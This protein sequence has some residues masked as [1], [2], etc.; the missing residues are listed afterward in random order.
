MKIAIITSVPMAP[1]WDQGDKNLAYALTQALNQHRFRI[2]TQRGGPVPSGA[3]LDTVPIY[4]SRRPSLLQKAFVYLQMLASYPA[5]GIP[6]PDS[7]SHGNLDIYHLIYQPT[8]LSASIGKWLPAF[9]RTPILHTVPS[10]ST[11]QTLHRG[12]FF[13]DRLVALSR[14]AQNCLE[15]MGFNNVT[16]IPVG[17]EVSSWS[18]LGAHARATK[19]RLGLSGHPVVLY[20]GHYTSGY[21]LEILLRAMPEVVTRIPEVK[22]IIACRMRSPG[23]RQREAAFK[24][25]I[26]RLGLAGNVFM[27]YSVTDMRTLIG[28]SDLTILPL[29]TMRDKIDTPTTLLESLAAGVPVI[30]SNLPPMNELLTRHPGVWGDA[31]GQTSAS[32]VGLAIPP[33]DAGALAQAILDLLGNTDLRERMGARGQKLVQEKYN[34]LSVARQ[35]EKLY[36]ELA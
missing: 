2:L 14:Y 19:A 12:L 28:A 11:G 15:S 24:A 20:P 5:N 18:G 26:N 7:L 22:F 16:H 25:E 36:R 9:Q 30:I 8:P 17:I 34:I 35:Y 21:G 31:A 3:N 32:D 29:L 33:A 6:P 27:Q 13:S 23:D 1:P 10:V 4:R